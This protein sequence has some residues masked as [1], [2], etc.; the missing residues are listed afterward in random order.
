M[1]G[2]TLNYDFDIATEGNRLIATV[3]GAEANTKA[4]ALSEGVAGGLA[5]VAQGADMVAGPGVANAAASAKGAGAGGGVAPA[6][7]S[8]VSGG[9]SR[10]KTGSHVDVSG[11]ALMAG[12]SFG[13]DLNAGRLTLGAFFEYGNGSYDTYNSFSTAS[14]RGK[15]DMRHAGGGVL[16]RMDFAAAGPGHAYGEGSVR[17]GV[18]HNEYRSSDLRDALGREASYETDAAWYGFHIGSGYVWN[19]TDRAS[20]DLYG[21]YF[22][23]RQKGDSAR[24]ST[25]ESVTFKDADS[26]RVRVGSR[27]AWRVNDI[28]SPYAGAAYEHEYD[29]KIRAATNGYA[30]DAPS[31]RGGTGIGELGLSLKPSKT[32]PL[33]FDLGVQGYVGKREGVT[34]SLQATCEF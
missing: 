34:G 7:F 15:G 25:G 32:L 6:G 31:L 22:W 13:A 24:L 17:A 2:V 4:K 3:T 8:A 30:I 20:F 1:Q 29:G 26:S 12:L 28:V 18:A 19:I 27:V 23:T 11:A 21:K 33:A 14:V 9:M 16:G 5:L 10:Y